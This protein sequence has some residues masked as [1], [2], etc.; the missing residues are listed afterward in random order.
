MNEKRQKTELESDGNVFKGTEPF[1]AIYTQTQVNLSGVRLTFDERIA[2]NVSDLG[3]QIETARRSFVHTGD[4]VKALQDI[5]RIAATY[6]Q[7][8][9]AWE[10]EAQRR[11]RNKSL[12]S[13]EKI[14]KM[15]AEHSRVRTKANL[16]DRALTKL[17]VEIHQLK[18]SDLV[19]AADTPTNAKPD[20]V[21]SESP[22]PTNLE[23]PT[24]A[25]F[26][27]E[28]LQQHVSMIS[29]AATQLLGQNFLISYDGAGEIINDEVREQ[30][31][32]SKELLMVV[33]W[34]DR[35]KK[36]ERV[37]DKVEMDEFAKP[38][39]QGPVKTRDLKIWLVPKTKQLSRSFQI[40]GSEFRLTL[41]G[42]GID[43]CE[44]KIT[45]Q[46]IVGSDEHDL[47]KSPRLRKF[48]DR[49]FEKI[50]NESE[51][52][53]IL[54]ADFKNLEPIQNQLLMNIID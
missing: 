8:V 4:K 22:Q 44:L 31:W 51:P 14:A 53:N 23:T 21:N 28:E 15:K 42:R 18:I 47:P 50:A 35:V 6:R 37:F 54:G 2:H 32:D 19:R 48:L 27:Q 10:A 29:E 52:L 36:T 30:A 26:S 13:G 20:V 12:V 3:A 49:V 41:E 46:T 9:Q 17:E 45:C 39:T 5:A 25:K 40:A 7:R 1:L 38:A 43:V 24:A 33:R 11:E 34:T 16:G